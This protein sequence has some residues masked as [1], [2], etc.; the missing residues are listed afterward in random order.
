MSRVQ[1][2]QPNI[3]ISE[4]IE[5]ARRS[6]APV[7]APVHGKDVVVVVLP[8]RDYEQWRAIRQAERLL[9][10]RPRKTFAEHLTETKRAL[11]RF[12]KKYK[13]TSAEFY[14]H[15]QTGQ[16]NEDELDYFDWRV[17]YNA[18][19]RMKKRTAHA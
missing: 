16:L 8:Q 15:F 6:A 2:S 10:K 12:E 19:L 17:E 11:R 9:V 4:L 13:M 1:S 14:R 5:K 3:A 18:F 7:E